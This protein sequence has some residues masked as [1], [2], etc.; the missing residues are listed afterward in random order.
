MRPA[1]IST[2]LGIGSDH[3]A[4]LGPARAFSPI[5]QSC[6]LTFPSLARPSCVS[7]LLTPPDT[8][9][10]QTRGL[11]APCPLSSGVSFTQPLPPPVK[12][13]PTFQVSLI[14]CYPSGLRFMSQLP[15]LG[16]HRP[17]LTHNTNHS[18]QFPLGLETP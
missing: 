2:P 7:A 6:F 8:L 9:R 14:L 3:P 18:H 4:F 17:V 1:V 15:R 10:F 16:S 11:H 12:I 13:L 5:F